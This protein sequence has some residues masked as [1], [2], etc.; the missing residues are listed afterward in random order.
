MG[1]YCLIAKRF[2]RCCIL[3]TN[4]HL[5]AGTRSY[6]EK[7]CGKCALMSAGPTAG[8]YTT[9]PI[10]KEIEFEPSTFMTLDSSRQFFWG[11]IIF[12]KPLRIFLLKG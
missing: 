9:Y 12:N 6:C 1:A 11:A 3:R 10:E 8:T 5:A 7:P 2:S 4:Y